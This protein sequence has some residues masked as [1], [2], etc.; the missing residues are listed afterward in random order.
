MCGEQAGRDARTALC[1]GSSPRVR[2]TGSQRDVE[3]AM[4]RIIPACAGNRIGMLMRPLAKADHPRV[5]GEQRDFVIMSLEVAGSSPRVRGTDLTR[6]DRACKRRII[7]ACAG[8]RFS[9]F[10]TTSV[11]PDHPRVCGEQCPIFRLY[12]SVSGSSPR[13]RGTGGRD[14]RFRHGV[15]IIPA[16]AGNSVRDPVVPARMPDHPRVCGEQGEY[17]GHLSCLLGSSPRVRGTA[18]NAA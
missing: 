12:E 6:R 2:G 17:P 8:N 11:K 13:V 15:R 9:G 7:P 4:G 3:G 5:C 18:S 14:P 1:I 16:C 10:G